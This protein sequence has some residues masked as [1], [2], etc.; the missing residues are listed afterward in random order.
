LTTLTEE[1]KTAF[2]WIEENADRI[3]D[4]HQLIWNYAETSFREYKSVKA[5]AKFHREE[6][7]DVELGVA[8]MPTAYVATWG[9]GKPV[10]ST[11][12]EYDAV[13]GQWQDPVPY[14]SAK[15]PYRAGHTD[16]HSALGVGAF[17]GAV[18]TKNA[19]E[20]HG[21]KGTIKVF[22]T[23]AE[24]VCAKPWFAAKGYFEGLDA[25]VTWHPRGASTV[26][27]E[28]QWGCYW[29]VAFVFECNEPEK[30][31]AYAEDLPRN[32]R[33]PGALDAICLMYTNTKY[34]KESML[35][36]TGLW[37]IN[38]AVLAAGQSTADNMSPR[39]GIITYAFRSPS[40]TQQEQI[41]KVLLNNAESV[42]KI[43]G[44]SLKVRWVTKGRT[45][46]FNK[47]LADLSYANLELVGPPKFTEDDKEKGRE[48]VK[49]LGY[50][51]PAEPFREDLTPPD[52]W[53]KMWRSTIPPHQ[54]KH[55]SD[56][57]VE[58]SWHCPT[59]WIQV[60]RPAI[61]VQGVRLPRWPHI[62]LG[63]MRGPIDRTIYTAG[64]T[65]SGT[66]LDLI[67]DPSKLKRCKDE[68]QERIAEYKEEPLLTP[69]MEPP[70]DLP[71]P[72]YIT[73]ER[74]YEWRI[75]APRE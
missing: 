28:T 45:G 49:A 19:L 25:A 35:P 32:A 44:C 62:A 47:A 68:F 51:P 18:A 36:R 3:S 5:Y 21:L 58:F 16:P 40:I 42:A 37:S 8:G 6:G 54:K 61:R 10:I 39:I 33:M 55:G 23:P 59:V 13:P 7:F 71:W 31:I 50:N 60:Y 12:T 15:N 75:P 38:E 4:F 43:T 48:L 34:T 66:M 41:Y 14:R 29:C 70:I 64:K 56:D 20:E 27:Y 11:Y 73:T 72:E 2:K 22:G 67:T 63:G 52:E 74:G 30:W 24:K 17:I 69:D 65:I 1:K 46:L 53:E 57:Y 26:M 9:E